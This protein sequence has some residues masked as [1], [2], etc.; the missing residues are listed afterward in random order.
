MEVLGVRRYKAGYEIRTEGIPA[1]ESASGTPMT[2]KSAFVS[3]TGEYIGSSKWAR[4]LMHVMGIVPEVRQKP[5]DMEANGGRGFPC[6]IGF[7][8]EEQKWYGWSHRAIFGF[9]LRHTVRIGDAGYV[10][11]NKHS[12]AEHCLQFWKSDKH[13]EQWAEYDIEEDG[14]LGIYVYW[15]YTDDVPN[16]ELRGEIGGIF[17]PYPKKWGKG[18]WTAMTLGDCRQMACDFAEAVN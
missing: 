11:D 7:C 6:S 1:E 4:K 2:M 14:V 13:L 17:E 5:N 18:E 8:E 16:Q 15:K 3:D 10:A 9:G 12:F